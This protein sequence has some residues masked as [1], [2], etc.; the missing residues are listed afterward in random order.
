MNTTHCAFTGRMVRGV[1]AFWSG[2][3]YESLSEENGIHFL[4]V[5]HIPQIE[6]IRITAMIIM[7]VM[8]VPEL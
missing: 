2:N 3:R 1:F 7:P 5:K 4:L 6:T 8:L